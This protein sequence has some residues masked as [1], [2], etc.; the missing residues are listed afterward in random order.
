MRKRT[1]TV[2]KQQRLCINLDN[3]IFLSSGEHSTRGNRLKLHKFFAKLDI[4]KYF[5]FVRTVNLWNALPDGI[6]GC[7]IIHNFVTKL[8]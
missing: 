4:R 7:K 2:F 8:K 5:F 6:V 3:C 1:R